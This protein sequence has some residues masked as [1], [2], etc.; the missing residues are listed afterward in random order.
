[1]WKA[2]DLQ[3]Q[4]RSPPVLQSIRTGAIVSVH[5]NL[6]TPTHKMLKKFILHCLCGEI[7]LEDAR[8]EKQKFA[9]PR[10]KGPG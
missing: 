1:V 8:K 7:L 4:G 5:R 9:K 2:D 6:N 3:I 10:N